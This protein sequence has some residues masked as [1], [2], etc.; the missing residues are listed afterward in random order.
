MKPM[1]TS[2][3]PMINSQF[4]E[5]DSSSLSSVSSTASSTSSLI[6]NVDPL[7]IRVPPKKTQSHQNVHAPVPTPRETPMWTIPCDTSRRNSSGSA[8][9]KVGPVVAPVPGDEVQPHHT[10]T[11]R[12]KPPRQ[13]RV[14]VALH[15]ILIVHRVLRHVGS[16]LGPPARRPLLYCLVIWSATAIA[17]RILLIRATVCASPSRPNA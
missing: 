7:P 1:A 6:N 2:P 11:E 14:P 10:P 4:G 17:G 16:S 3:R 12:H 15:P 9:I 8:L 13:G 5:D